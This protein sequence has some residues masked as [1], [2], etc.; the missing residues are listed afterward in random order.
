MNDRSPTSQS[1]EDA[2]Q[3]LQ[4]AAKRIGITPNYISDL[5][6]HFMVKYVKIPN[7]DPFSRQRLAKIGNHI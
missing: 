6:D 3:R 1:A 7:W 5:V 2:R 4:M